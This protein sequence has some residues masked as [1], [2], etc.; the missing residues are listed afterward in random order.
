MVEGY[1]IMIRGKVQEKQWT[2]NGELEAKVNKIE[3]LD[4]IRESRVSGININIP[5]QLIDDDL[6]TELANLTLENKGNVSLRFSIYDKEDKT[7]KAQ[8][9]SRSSKIQLTDEIIEYL[10]SYSDISFSLT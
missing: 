2:K 8:F 10:E 5:L 3:M 4:G 9:L 7:N 1:Y 6:V